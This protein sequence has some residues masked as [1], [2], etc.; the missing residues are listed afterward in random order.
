MQALRLDVSNMATTGSFSMVYCGAYEI[1][2]RDAPGDCWDVRVQRLGGAAGRPGVTREFDAVLGEY[3]PSIELTARTL[4]SWARCVCGEVATPRRST[5]YL[6]ATATLQRTCTFPTCM[7]FP[8][9]PPGSCAAALGRRVPRQQL[10]LH[11]E[12]IVLQLRRTTRLTQ[13]LDSCWLK[14]NC[15]QKPAVEAHGWDGQPA[16]QLQFLNPDTIT[17]VSIRLPWQGALRADAAAPELHVGMQST[18]PVEVQ[19]AYCDALHDQV[20]S[21]L[22]P[23]IGYIPALCIAMSATLNVTP[24]PGAEEEVSG[25]EADGSAANATPGGAEKQQRVFDNPLFTAN[26]AP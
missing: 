14:L 5:A 13:Q 18:E 8:T 25:S 7:P 1:T 19:Q 10:S 6:P 17:K 20:L 2:C 11:L 22:Q 4:L 26:A 24:G 16:L 23:G 15:M 12:D 9:S 21:R 3:L